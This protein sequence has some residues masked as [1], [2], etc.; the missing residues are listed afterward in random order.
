[1]GS[2]WQGFLTMLALFPSTI[3]PEMIGILICA[4]FATGLI[5]GGV[6]TAMMLERSLSGY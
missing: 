4:A 6:I 2:E 3:S 5:L 1:L